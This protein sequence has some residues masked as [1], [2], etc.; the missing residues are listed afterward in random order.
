MQKDMAD[1]VTTTAS[2]RGV[3]TETLEGRNAIP[4]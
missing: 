4:E 2:V 3:A 1:L